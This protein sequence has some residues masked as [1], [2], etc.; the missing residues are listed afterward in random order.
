MA[1]DG[2]MRV[3]YP[4]GPSSKLRD[5]EIFAEAARHAL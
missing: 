5:L 3:V 4:N 1:R 2:A